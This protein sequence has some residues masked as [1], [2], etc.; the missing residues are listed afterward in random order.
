MFLALVITAFPA[1]YCA[2]ETQRTVP[3][4]PIAKAMPK[5]DTLFG[6]IRIDNYF[7]LRDKANPEV[8][9]YLEAENAYT[10]S[11]TAHLK[12]LQDGLYDEMVDRLV[13]TDTAAPVQIDN[14]YYYTRTVKDQQYPIY[15]RKEVTPSGGEEILLDPNELNYKYISLGAFKVSPDHKTLAYAIDTSGWE[16]YAVYVKD[17]QEP[18]FLPDTINNTGGDLEWANDNM[19]FFYTTLDSTQRPFE[20]YRHQMG[21]QQEADKLVYR[22]DDGA[23]Y[24][25]LSKT[26]SKKF[27]VVGL[28]SIVTSEF[29]T[30]DADQPSG[31]FRI[32]APRRK[33]IEYS[34]DHRGDEFFIMTNDNARNFKVMRTPIGNPSPD[35]WT[36]FIPQDDSV[37]IEKIDLFQNHLVIS[38]RSDGLPRL[39]IVD[40]GTDERHYVDFPDPAYSIW[41]AQNPVYETGVFRFNYSSLVTPSSVFDYDMQ[42]RDRKLVKQNR[43]N[44]Y[45]AADYKTERLW[46]RAPDGIPVPIVVAYKTALFR[47]DGSNPMMLEGYGA[48]GIPSNPYFSFTNVSLLDRGFVYAIAQ[49]RGGGEMGRWWYE[50]GKLLKKKNTFTDFIACAEYLTAN[51]YTSKD[52]LAILGG[53]AGGILI[54]A[55]VNMR[56]DLFRVAVA[57][58][59]FVDVLNTMLDPTIPLTVVEYDEWGNP[60]DSAYYFY[61]KGYSPYD[62]VE[63]KAYPAL[64]IIGGLNDPRV[65]YWEPTKWAAKLRASKTDGNPL[66]L[67][68]HMGE[69]HFGVSGRYARL[70]EEAFIY[71][72]C[73]DVMGMAK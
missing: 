57:G 25:G 4:P 32:V 19:T 50:D 27:I 59:P 45:R 38:E 28:Q 70:K 16:S 11:M 17:L 30:L 18:R 43:V 60:H 22:E 44:N 23:F 37:K 58:S 40:L 35:N 39:R 63:A 33:E 42:S 68:V 69:G 36:E 48:Y 20:L 51:K 2:R 9:K 65:A 54:G 41:A 26:R 1:L 67:L 62:N 64:L 14:Y 52:K 61:I 21:T 8:I 71:S 72:Y 29:W 5:A 53:S 47:G 13:E 24:L 49:A 10:D 15:C 7:W 73:L 12:R 31:Q 34:L 56:P 55:A 46:A 66:L 6:D 3:A